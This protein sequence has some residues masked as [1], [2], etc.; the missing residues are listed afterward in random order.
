MQ[1]SQIGRNPTECAQSAIASMAV[2]ELRIVANELLEG[3]RRSLHEP[4]SAGQHLDRARRLLGIEAG[5]QTLSG[6]SP[7]RKPVGPILPAWLATRVATHIEANL[8]TALRTEKMADVAGLSYSH[9]SRAFR[10]TF[11]ITPHGYLIRRRIGAAQRLM[12]STRNSLCQIAI[13][14]GHND[15][16]HF[17]RL[18]RREVGETPGAWRRARFHPVTVD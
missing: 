10:A 7:G 17:C 13:D 14:T 8:A 15:Q 1:L 18:F 9:F 16:A 5:S 2:D 3:L 4:D 6:P 11:G 12:L